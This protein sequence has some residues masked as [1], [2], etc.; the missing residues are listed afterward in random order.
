[1]DVSGYTANDLQLFQNVLDS[2]M[3]EAAARDLKITMTMMARRLFDA[4]RD[5]E[6]NPDRLKAALLQSIEPSALAPVFRNSARCTLDRAL[7]R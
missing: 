3:T 7:A 1:M 4:A 5:G 6:R 2:A